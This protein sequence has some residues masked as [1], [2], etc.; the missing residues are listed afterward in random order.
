[1]IWKERQDEK[2]PCE[3]TSHFSR[4]WLFIWMKHGS[5]AR[6]KCEAYWGIP[7]SS[8]KK[9]QLL[10]SHFWKLLI[11]CLGVLRVFP[12]YLWCRIGGACL[13]LPGEFLSWI[14]EEHL[15]LL[16]PK[17]HLWKCSAYFKCWINLHHDW[18]QQTGTLLAI[19]TALWN[20]EH[21]EN[22]VLLGVKSYSSDVWVLLDHQIH[23]L[24][25]ANLFSLAYSPMHS[26]A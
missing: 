21:K 14:F 17:P 19:I 5:P 15:N 13:C 3:S 26:S 16:F 1:M 23:C 11:L 10:K 24:S 2:C 25:S 20:S 22:K 6:L 7:F 4:I 9:P 12:T 8:G 18:H